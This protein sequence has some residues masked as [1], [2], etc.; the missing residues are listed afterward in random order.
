MTRRRWIAAW[1]GLLALACT[2]VPAAPPP[3]RLPR[4][5]LAPAL[6]TPPVRPASSFR[7]TPEARTVEDHWILHLYTWLHADDYE[8]LRVDFRASDG[9][10]GVAHL[11]LPP[12]RGPHPAVLVFPIL[13]GSYVV[14]EALAKALVNRGY[15]VLRLERR[16]LFPEQDPPL[17]FAEP[18][19]RLRHALLDARLLLDWLE[20]HPD[21]D[22]HR[23]GSAG[24]SIGGIMAATLL[25]VDE[26]VR[27]GFFVM[28]GGGLAEIL[29]ESTERPVR[30]FRDRV[31]ASLP[32]PSRKA[33]LAAARP[34]TEPLDPLTYADRVDPGQ[35]LLISG[36]FD[37]VVPP[38]RTRALW[39]AL[40]RPPWHRFP[41][42]HY[43]L[44]PFFWWGVGRGA[45][46]LD[47]ALAAPE[48]LPVRRAL[49]PSSPTGGSSRLDPA[50]IEQ[51]PEVLEQPVHPIPHT[52]S[53]GNGALV[54]VDGEI[55][56]GGG[57]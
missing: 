2:T 37:R 3:E 25:A 20:R 46:H 56:V 15:A 39:E 24:V 4:S 28:A 5:G 17:H 34:Y 1:L 30:A 44:F 35:A 47:R 8:A 21:V 7:V 38:A 29:Y 16:P 45:D 10:P 54:V 51:E 42:G 9:G 12:G 23:I 55:E 26:R 32:E 50:P 52:G 19:Q 22:P 49:P 11:L 48:P 43:Q 6:L 31:L 14:S 33:F 13:S 40:G 41:G 18:A 36:R 53:G 27:A 57:Q